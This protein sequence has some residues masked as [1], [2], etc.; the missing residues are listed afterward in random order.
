[1][2]RSQGHVLALISGRLADSVVW[3]SGALSA[4]SGRRGSAP[5][6][7]ASGS[8]APTGARSR[9]TGSSR[10]TDASPS[11]LVGSRQ[12]RCIYAGGTGPGAC[13]KA[14]GPVQNRLVL[15]HIS[16]PLISPSP[17]PVVRPTCRPRPPP[18]PLL[19]L[20]PSSQVCVVCVVLGWL[21]PPWTAG[22]L[23]HHRFGGRLEARC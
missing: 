7:A 20:G 16:P 11:Y 17:K 22:L 1:M 19:C 4:C 13:C 18:W 8:G 9:S 23:L 5:G 15:H 21:H 6:L 12:F 10:D 3:A 14:A 2:P